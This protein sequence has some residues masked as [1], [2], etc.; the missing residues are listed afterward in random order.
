MYAFKRRMGRRPRRRRQK[1][2]SL[3]RIKSLFRSMNF[4]EGGQLCLIAQ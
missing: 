4:Y 3:R 2:L 1:S